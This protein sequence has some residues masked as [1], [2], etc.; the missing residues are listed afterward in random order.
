M[1][2]NQDYAPAASANPALSRPAVSQ[3]PN[4]GALGSEK[5]AA[6]R[7][8]YNAAGDCVATNGSQR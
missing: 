7:F 5:R 4:A 8:I 6:V 3:A 1:T 2:I